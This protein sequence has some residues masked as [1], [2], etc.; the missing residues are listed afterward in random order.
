[1]LKYLP[2]LVVDVGMKHAAEIED[3]EV[4]NWSVSMQRRLFGPVWLPGNGALAA[5]SRR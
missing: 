5:C 4:L 3:A 2:G 1:M